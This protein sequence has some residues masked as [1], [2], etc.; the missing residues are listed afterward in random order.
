MNED[1]YI[2]WIT[3]FATVVTAIYV[4][5]QYS[6]SLKKRGDDLFK[7]RWDLYQE[8]VS[9]IREWQELDEENC[10]NKELDEEPEDYLSNTGSNKKEFRYIQAHDLILKTSLLFDNEIAN[11]LKWLITPGLDGDKKEEFIDIRYDN[12]GYIITICVTEEFT[13]KF[14]KYLRIHNNK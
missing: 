10:R 14:D 9:K 11:W 3:C 8:I 4:Y 12:G 13:R 5:F 2:K 6:V 1:S 7:T